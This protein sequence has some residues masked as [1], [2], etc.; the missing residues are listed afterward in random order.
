[1]F[2]FFDFRNH[3]I[4]HLVPISNNPLMLIKLKHMEHRG[5]SRISISFPYSAE[6]GQQIKPS[7]TYSLFEKINGLTKK[8]NVFKPGH[9]NIKTT[10][11][12]THI[13]NKAMTQIASPLGKLVM[14][15][16]KNVE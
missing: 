11:I 13:S 9:P 4:K 16:D 15:N 12:N 5:T 6:L 2:V 10:M 8:G 7:T 3:L 14:T 1:M